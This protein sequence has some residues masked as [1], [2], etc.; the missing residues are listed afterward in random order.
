MN[1]ELRIKDLKYLKSSSLQVF[2]YFHPEDDRPLDEAFSS[3]FG[4]MRRDVA[5]C[6]WE[7]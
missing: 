4:K 5:V 3:H 1:H 7:E 2:R 6:F